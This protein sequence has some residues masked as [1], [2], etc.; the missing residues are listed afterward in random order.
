MVQTT[1]EQ[2]TLKFSI[3]LTVILGIIGVSSGLATGSQAII[4]DGMYS[5]VDVAPTVVSLMVVKLL[6]RGSSRRFQYGYWHLEPLVAV[7]R[8][9]ILV[10]ACIYAAIDAATTLTSGG[11]DVS[12]GLAAA[13]VGGFCVVG[14]V[15][16][17]Y[18]GRRARMLQ[19]PMLR[20]DARSWMVSAFLSLALLIG[21]TIAIALEGTAFEG[22]IPYL[23]AIALLTMALIMLPMPLFGLGRSI[24]DV[25]QVAPDELD[26]RVHSVMDSIVKERGF[27]DY[28]SYVAKAGRAR[29][30]EIH[31]LVAP[32]WHVDISAADDVRRDISKRLNATSPDFWLTIDFTADRAWL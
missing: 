29:F 24:I 15:M 31:V 27:V 30:V 4:F 21:F 19:S 3:A 25:L 12:Y 28:S 18:L 7:L 32:G 22:W 16:T 14:L 5:F 2:N 23:D 11:Q 8:D 26:H 1:A 10:I 9:S 17:W 20:L 6:A 13:W